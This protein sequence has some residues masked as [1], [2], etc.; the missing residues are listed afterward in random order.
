MNRGTL[1]ILKRLL[2]TALGVLGL[3]ALASG[4]AFGQAPPGSSNIPAPDVFDDQI[5]CTQLLPSVMG[6]NLPST[7]PMG[8]MTSPLDDIIGDGENLLEA[9][10][11]V[12]DAVT[13]GPAKLMGLGY[14]IPADNMNCGG[15]VPGTDG[16]ML[17]TMNIDANTDGDFLDAGDTLAW[18]SIP[19]DVADGYS[20]LLTK[21]VA[22]YGNPGGTTGGTLRALEAAQKLVD[23]TDTSLEALLEARV[24]AR[25]AAQE[26]HNKALAAFNAASRGPIYQAGV[27]EWKAK[28]A[29]T[30]GIDDYNKQVT[31]TNEVKMALDAMQ[32]SNWD[33]GDEAANFAVTQGTSKYVPLTNTSLVGTV[34]TINMGMGTVVLSELETYTG[35][36]T[37]MVVAGT[38][39]MAATGVGTADAMAATVSD[40]STSNFTTL[41]E[42]IVPMTP[43]SLDDPT[44]GF[45]EALIPTVSANGATVNNIGTIRTTVENVRIAAAALKKARDENTN[46]RFQDLYDEAYRRANLEQQ[47]Y[48]ALWSRV[49]A[50]NTDTRLAQQRLQY[51]DTNSNGIN[52]ASEQTT[53]NLNNDSNSNA[54]A[55]TYYVAN[56][57]TIASRNAAY[58]TESANRMNEETSLRALVA[59]REMATAG[60]VGQFT[61][62]QSFYQQLVDRRQALKNAADKVV[63]D[64]T[65]PSAAQTK[66]A[67]DAAKALMAAQ[68]EKT[69][70]DALFPAGDDNPVVGLVSELLKTGG[71]DGQALV[72]AIS[73]TYDGTQTNKTNIEGLT[74]KVNMLTGEGEGGTSVTQIADDLAALTA[75]DDPA[76][77]DVD[78]RGQ[79][80][81]N[82]DN[83]ADLGDDV[84]AVE[85]DLDGVWMDV[86][87][88]PRG[89]EMQHEGL[90]ACD[91]AGVLN[92]ANCALTTANHNAD[93][94]DDLGSD[95]E[96]L[97]GRVGDNEDDIAKL[98]GEDGLIAM[99]DKANADAIAAE[100]TARKEADDALGVRIDGEATARKEA[101]DALGVRIDGEATARME[102]DDALGVR[103]DGEATARMEADDALGVRIDG[104]ATA[105]ME[106]DDALGVRIDGEAEARMGADTALGGRIDAES[107][108]RMGADMMLAEAIG[109]EAMYR[110][111]ADMALGE[112]IMANM[113]AI[114]M[115]GEARM[116]ADMMLAGAIEEAVAAGVAS[117]MALSG[118]INSNADAIAANMNSIGQ[119][120]SAISDNRNMIGELSDDLDVVRAGV[121]A[122]MALAGMPAVN[123]R[124]I[125]I[126]VGSFD[127]ESAFA[128]G[129]QIQGEQ[130]SFKIGV[131]SSGGATGASA[132]VGFQF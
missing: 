53:A 132:G 66:A 38:P 34:V 58:G 119:N 45:N 94:I 103:I 104:E 101:D 30:K 42:L 39:A 3:G 11:T 82:E 115:E 76:T 93:D 49:L 116:G 127:G 71:D 80:T 130:A 69:K 36:T 61:D 48:D 57:V 77:M 105:R 64:A 21:F 4:P 118:R 32:Y 131:T 5:T 89:V 55:A 121:A 41:G 97:E 47:Y 12:F 83:I 16:P 70:I 106:A 9:G 109:E 44:D 85:E 87:G 92:V 24:R 88:T 27:T 19:E 43:A 98:T 62:A 86:Y 52:E 84:A 25:D 8:G 65:N 40:S 112:A 23:G 90:A 78:E 99:G 59:A 31:K 56:P 79:V 29:V 113:D 95:I 7:V 2:A 123:G 67:A 51:V 50:D 10:D 73:N 114:V 14:V 60:V 111:S 13:D 46:P 75:Q 120:A 54:A 17:G 22:V 81:K 100:A 68:D 15:G 102:A 74:E 26:A 72:D 108:A 18:G 20:E 35:G 96:G 33:V 63:A 110:E 122:S 37:G 6:F 91:A 128:V 126:G 129:F 117:D 107:E 28:A 124:G 1:M 125:A